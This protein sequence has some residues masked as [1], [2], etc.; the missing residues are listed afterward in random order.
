MRID[1]LN[2]DNRLGLIQIE[3]L[4]TDTS[5]QP[6]TS[7]LLGSLPILS[8]QSRHISINRQPVPESLRFRV[9]ATAH[10]RCFDEITVVIKP[11]L[12]RA[13]AGS[14]IAIQDFVLIP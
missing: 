3:L 12:D 2:G 8:S 13:L 9:P 11:S 4:L 5:R 14:K 6:A 7:I 1:L 10:G